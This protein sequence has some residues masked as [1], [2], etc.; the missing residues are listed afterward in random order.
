MDE[1]L[2]LRITGV[3]P[4]DEIAG[5]RKKLG[6]EAR[7]FEIPN[8]ILDAWRAAGRRSVEAHQQWNKRLIQKETDTVALTQAAYKAGMRPLRVSG[9]TKVAQGLTTFEE[10][11]KSAPLP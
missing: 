10:V 4:G 11:L 5:A 1:G 3:E 9:A 6:W 2:T 8:D 7:A